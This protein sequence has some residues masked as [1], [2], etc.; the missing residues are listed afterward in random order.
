MQQMDSGRQ[1]SA[2]IGPH[3]YSLL[4]QSKSDEVNFKGDNVKTKGTVIIIIDV[5]IF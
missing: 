5:N 2:L 4:L 1:R 3:T